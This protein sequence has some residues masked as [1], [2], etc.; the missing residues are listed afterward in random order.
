MPSKGICRVETNEEIEIPVQ[1]KRKA[2]LWYVKAAMDSKE[3]LVEAKVL[4]RSYI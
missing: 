1:L 3:G 4:D 2:Y